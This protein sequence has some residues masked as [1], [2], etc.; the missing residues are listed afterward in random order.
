MNRKIVV[1]NGSPRRNGNTSA[2]IESF[3]KGAEEA[4]NSVTAFFLHGMDIHPCLGCYGGGK[5]P[6]SPCV[7]KDAMDTIYPAFRDADV[8][9]LASPLYFWNISGQLKCAVDRLFAVAEGMPNYQMPAKECA[10][11][12]AAESNEYEE[13]VYYYTRLI[14]HLGWKDIG[15]VLAPGVLAAGDIKGKPALEDARKLGASIK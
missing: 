1:L 14:D 2:L 7:Q 10:L 9:V 11:L 3:T 13:T 15:Q 8:V 12:M 4:G 5:D 6:D